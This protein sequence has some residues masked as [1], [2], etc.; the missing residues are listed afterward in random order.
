M[1]VSDIFIF[2]GFMIPNIEIGGRTFS[3]YLILVLIGIFV[4]GP[5]CIRKVDE[6]DRIE[7]LTVLL[8]TAPGVLIGGHLLYGITNIKFLINSIVNWSGFANIW[9]AFGGS[10]FYGGMLGG[11]ASA[12]IYTKIKKINI[13]KYIGPSAMFIPLFHVFGRIGCFLSGC[14]FGVESEIGFIYHHSPIDMANG[15]RRFPIQ[16]VEAFGNLLIFL[17]LW[18]IFKKYIHLHPKMIHI[19]FTAYSVMRFTLEFFRGDFYRGFLFGLSTSQIISIIIFI[20][21]ATGI[22]LYFMKYLKEKKCVL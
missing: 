13:K 19:Y 1:W 15:V 5:F 17:M 12:C 10:V 18:Y 11:I 8:W 14:C 16:L 20:C 21:G 2:G 22:I 4:A 7:Y 9:N 6:D 3:A